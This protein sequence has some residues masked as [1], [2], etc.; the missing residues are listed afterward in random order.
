M[1]LKHPTKPLVELGQ[2]KE[3]E[4]DIDAP[5]H[6]QQRLVDLAIRQAARNCRVLSATRCHQK[7]NQKQQLTL[8][9]GLAVE[10]RVTLADPPP[11]RSDV[12]AIAIPTAI[13]LYPFQ[14]E[15]PQAARIVLRH[16]VDFSK[17]QSLSHKARRKCSTATTTLEEYACTCN[18]Y[19]GGR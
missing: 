11:E 19:A 6:S 13:R 12:D 17:F 9:V 10:S 5:Q 7:P 8:K 15:D 3:D 4:E 2:G 16:L 14:G 18:E 1:L